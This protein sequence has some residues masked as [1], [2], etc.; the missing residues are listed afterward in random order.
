MRVTLLESDRHFLQSAECALLSLLAHGAVIVGAIAVTSGG[1]V[2][3]SNAREARVFFLLPPDRVAAS[4]S[5]PAIMQW[6]REGGDLKDGSELTRPGEGW[7]THADAHGRRGKR[8]KSGAKGELPVG[9]D[10]RQPDSVFSVLEVD[11]VVQ[12]YETSAAPVYPPELLATGTEGV[13]YAQFVVDT[14]GMVDTTTIRLLT[15]PHPAF[16]ASVRRALGLMR[17][18][19]AVRGRHKVRQLV[20][21]HFRF[22]IAPPVRQIS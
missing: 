6:G 2:L 16:S 3:P 14:S 18:R 11:S 13:V 1:R 4:S 12:R 9:P 7:L 5:Q 19:P 20:E 15:S 17:F 10:V 22:T 21:Q 8:P